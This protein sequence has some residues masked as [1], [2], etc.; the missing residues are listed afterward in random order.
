MCLVCLL[1]MVVELQNKNDLV[2]GGA[3]VSTTTKNNSNK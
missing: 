2:S 3:G 1:I